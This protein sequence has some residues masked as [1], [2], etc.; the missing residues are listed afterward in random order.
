MSQFVGTCDLFKAAFPISATD[1]GAQ[2]GGGGGILAVFP[3][4]TVSQKLSS[5]LL[6]SLLHICGVRVDNKIQLTSFIFTTVESVTWHLL[7]N[8]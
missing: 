5:F 1:C 3:N 8:T 7:R 6:L 2:I 4:D